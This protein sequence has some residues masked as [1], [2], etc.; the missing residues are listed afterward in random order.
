VPFRWT[1]DKARF[2]LPATTRWLVIRLWAHHPDIEQEPVKVAI[3]APC[4]T[5]FEQELRSTTP[6]S[7]GLALPSSTEAVDA[8]VH[9]SRTWTPADTGAADT[10]RLGVGILTEFVPDEELGRAQDYVV[11]WPD[12]PPR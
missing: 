8:T 10:R 7:V 1:D 4:G 11:D 6:V 9:V 3:V 12:C 5:A 2:L